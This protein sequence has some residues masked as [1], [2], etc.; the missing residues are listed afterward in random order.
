MRNDANS[1]PHT[2]CLYIL[3]IPSCHFDDHR[4]EKSFPSLGGNMFCY[5]CIP[6]VDQQKV[7]NEIN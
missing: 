7:G 5:G 6:E 3:D 1:W 4:E 2:P